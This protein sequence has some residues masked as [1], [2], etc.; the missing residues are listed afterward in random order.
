MKTSRKALRIKMFLEEASSYWQNKVER[1]K[2]IIIGW[3][4][5]VITNNK[6]VYYV[7]IVNII[8]NQ[9]YVI[10]NRRN[11]EKQMFK[12]LN[13]TLLAT[14]KNIIKLINDYKINDMSF[15]K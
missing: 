12:G 13:N 6:V 4:F 15:Y 2:K 1:N 14:N 8:N 10:T 5:M 9:Y 7:F 11:N 3:F